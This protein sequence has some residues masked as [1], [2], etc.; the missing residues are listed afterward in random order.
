MKTITTKDYSSE[1]LRLVIMLL[2]EHQ[3]IEY[4]EALYF[5][6]VSLIPEKQVPVIVESIKSLCKGDR[7]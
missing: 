2:L 7:K 3:P 1:I 4:R 6:I 5:R